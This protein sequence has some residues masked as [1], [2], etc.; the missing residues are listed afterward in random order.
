MASITNPT[1]DANTEALEVAKAFSTAIRGKTVLITGTNV[2]GIGF[3]TAQAFVSPF[4]AY[5]AVEP[6]S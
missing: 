4:K 3:T 1:F 6:P 2:H 5:R